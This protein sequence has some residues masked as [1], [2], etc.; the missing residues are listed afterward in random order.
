MDEELTGVQKEILEDLEENGIKVESVYNITDRYNI[1]YA[2]AH[3]FVEALVKAGIRRKEE[4]SVVGNKFI[5]E[6]KKL[7]VI[8]K[9]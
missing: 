7:E 2:G 5:L 4:Y 3:K 6:I 8:Q 9:L 1:P